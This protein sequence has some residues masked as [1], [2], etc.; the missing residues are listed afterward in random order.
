MPDAPPDF[1]PDVPSREQI[2]NAL[3]TAGA[4]LSPAEL[5]QRMGVER[6]ATMVGFERRLAAMERDGQ[7]LPNRK[8]VLLL[9]TKLDFVAGRVQGHRDGFGF[10]VRDDGGPDIFL[11]PREMLKVLHGDRV[12]VKPSGE[13]RGKPEGT[14]VEVIER[15][16]NKLVG[17][18]LHEH[19]LSIVVPED[20]RIKH[21]ILIPPGDTNG[22]QHGQVVSVEIIE[23]P[24]RHTQPLGKV[25]EVLGEIDDPGMEIEI[26]V[27]KFDVPVEFSE[28][29]RKQAARLPDSVRKSDLKERVDLRDV[30]LITIDGEDARD[31][32]DA[33][34]CQP[35]DLGTGQRKRPGWRL[36]VA[37]A[38]VSHY[39]RPGDALDDDA[40]ERGTSVYF[41]RRVIPMLP[42][43]LSNGLCSLNPNVDRLVLV[44]DMVIPA[45][46][47]KAGT[48]SAY[49][50]YNAV[51]HSHAR[52]TYTSIW[53]ALQQP[54]GPAA[55]AL[56]KLLP[57]VQHLYELYQLLAQ[58]RKKRGAIDFETVE[59]RIVCNELGR[60]EQIVPMVRND[61]HKLIEECMLAANTCAA[62]FMQ[63]SKHPGLYRIHEG[64]TPERLQ[65]LRD[66]LRTMALSLGGGDTPTAKDYGEFLDSVRA[67]PD[68]PLL[69]TMSL[70]SMQQA[71][72]SPDNMGH[73]G[74][75]YPAYSHFTSP[76]R[77]YPDL[78]THRV[79]KALLA[80]QRYVPELLSQPMVIGRSQREHEH[81]IWEKLGLILSAS[82]RRADE[83]SRDVEAWLKCWFVKERVGEDFSGTV[84]GVASFGIF[85]TL[86]TLHVEGLVHVSEL[87]SEYFQ[88]NDSLHELRGE[89]TGMRY[90]LT[91][92]VQVQVSR[93]DLEA[94]R[95]EFRLVKGTS[96][97][98]L[99]KQSAR[100]P[101][102]PRR[103]KKAAAPKPAALKGQT[104][105][106][107][108]AEAKK[109]N[110]VPATPAKR[111]GAPAKKA[112][113]GRH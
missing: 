22:A 72:Y 61:A 73:F 99:R 17:R 111:A 56:G 20:Q 46:G 9:A 64:P 55:H 101:D 63:R 113:R 102:E 26:A 32:D 86:D 35:V 11:S 104:A 60:I 77:R 8:G 107:R 21:D 93:V 75:A 100:N 6:E 37:I 4:P 16:T 68:F 28:A 85:V 87:G 78:L 62:D 106:Q 44:C 40:A 15:R 34:Y 3:R 31:F 80:G 110:K 53:E 82:E 5:A 10:L 88:F 69:Q 18:F 112:V 97:E 95:I 50:F 1:D 74:L 81:A 41:P 98:A 30:P 67:R 65:A 103:V 54:G 89:R 12:L 79:I 38:D 36:L 2:L 52:T 42:E 23:Q 45:T 91:D 39:V 33:V 58:Q 94:R 71:V 92:K 25:F 19:G 109:A 66:F 84:T 47:A 57:D 70:R 83:A 7:L 108:R 48:V 24:T 105:K 96:Y 90:R 51:M 29:A 43:S 14:I 27:R 59:T 13:Y 49:Q 76:I